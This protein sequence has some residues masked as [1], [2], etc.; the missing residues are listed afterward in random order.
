MTHAR[1]L[2]DRLA[3]HAQQTREQVVLLLSTLP[4]LELPDP[5]QLLEQASGGAQPRAKCLAHA[6][7]LVLHQRPRLAQQPRQYPH[8]VAE[9]AAVDAQRAGAGDLGLPRQYR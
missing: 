3:R 6:D 7:Q 8:A 5:M 1:R 9:Q 2:A 4:A